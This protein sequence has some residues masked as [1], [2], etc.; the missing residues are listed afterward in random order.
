M[1]PEHMVQETVYLRHFIVSG[2]KITQTFAFKCITS[3]VAT[4]VNFLIAPN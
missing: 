1:E 2:L 3:S 4:P